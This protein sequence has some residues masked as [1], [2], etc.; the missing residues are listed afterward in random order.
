MEKN[1]EYVCWE[2]GE[3][4]W[5]AE[6]IL[7]RAVGQKMARRRLPGRSGPYLIVSRQWRFACQVQ[8]SMVLDTLAVIEY[9]DRAR[10]V[11]RPSRI[12]VVT[13]A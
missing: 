8:Y 2:R 5:F 3:W 7:M 10:S 13:C 6:R 12:I 9:Y 1:V 4:E 11:A